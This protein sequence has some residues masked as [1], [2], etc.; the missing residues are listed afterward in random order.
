M[1]RCKLFLVLL[2]ITNGLSKPMEN[3]PNRCC[4]PKRSSAKL[5]A[6][7]DMLSSD[8]TL[9]TTFI[10][11]EEVRDLENGLLATRGPTNT[12]IVGLHDH[13]HRIFDFKNR[14]FYSIS[15]DGKSC[16]KHHLP[17]SPKNCIEESENYVNTSIYNYNG[18]E[19]LADTWTK[20]NYGLLSYR[21]VSRDS[22]LLLESKYIP[23]NSELS[24]TLI[25]Y[26]YAEDIDR[27]IF[28]IP[29]EC[30]S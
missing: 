17:D 2:F 15:A 25:T 29:S 16:L 11:H 28:E 3:P 14:L 19:V 4:F 13:F 22:C 8:G 10:E 5:V 9:I 7:A 1:F 12:S 6:T 30:L 21:T 23:S 18:K 24:G 26:N 27:S 20:Y